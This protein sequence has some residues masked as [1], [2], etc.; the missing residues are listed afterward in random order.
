MQTEM[1]W[2]AVSMLV[3]ALNYSLHNNFYRCN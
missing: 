3:H 1:Q 2:K